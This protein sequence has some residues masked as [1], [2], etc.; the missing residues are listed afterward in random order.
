ASAARPSAIR[1]ASK[2][3]SPSTGVSRP[4]STALSRITGRYTRM[5]RPR[6]SD[7]PLSADTGGG[8]VELQV[9]ATPRQAQLASQHVIM[10]QS[11]LL[12][13]SQ[14]KVD[15]VAEVATAEA[16]VQSQ[17]RRFLVGNLPD[18]GKAA[19]LRLR[20]RLRHWSEVHPRAQRPHGI[21]ERQAD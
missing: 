18:P 19:P 16:G 15:D 8:Q 5:S 12:A 20:Q 17:P 7:I 10:V 6:S 11:R 14:V 2:R 1:S 21:N 13:R 4:P 3:A 9:D